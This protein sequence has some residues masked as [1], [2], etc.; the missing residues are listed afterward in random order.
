MKSGVHSSV[1][2][3]TAN[4]P[5]T[6]VQSHRSLSSGARKSVVGNILSATTTNE[7]LKRG[8]TLPP[9]LPSETCK[10]SSVK[11]LCKKGRLQ[12]EQKMYPA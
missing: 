2:L 11:R 9:V 5:S 6:A 4:A 3:M 7:F 8:G 10:E 1:H 12:T